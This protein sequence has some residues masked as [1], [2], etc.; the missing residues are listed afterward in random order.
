M[1][2][3]LDE[4]KEVSKGKPM[5]WVNLG[6]VWKKRRLRIVL[7]VMSG[8]QRLCGSKVIN[9][10]SAGRVHRRCMALAVNSTAVGPDGALHGGYQKPPIQVLNS[11]NDLAL[12]AVNN[13]ANS[14]PMALI[15]QL[16]P[17]GSTNQWKE[18]RLVV[19]HLCHVKRL[20]KHI[21]GK[22][23]SMHAHLNAFDGIDFGANEHGILVA[24]AEDH[25]HS[26]ESGI[27]LNLAEVAY[28]GLTDSE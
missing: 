5:M 6:G 15:Q 12:M 9:N 21:L 23:F 24:T 13:N 22:V 4:V 25:L 1:S 27:M 19:Q 20:S 16:L 7:S 17:S 26:C 10:G 18:K 28:G 11:L 8:D 2:V 3:L 14:G